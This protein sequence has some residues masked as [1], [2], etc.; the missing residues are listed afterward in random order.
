MKNI[1]LM[2]DTLSSLLLFVLFLS[3]VAFIIGLIMVAASQ[4]TRKTGIKIMIGA[5]IAFIIGFGTCLANL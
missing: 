2:S 4:N 5:A 1:T 3:P